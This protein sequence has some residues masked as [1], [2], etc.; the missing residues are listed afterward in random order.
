MFIRKITIYLLVISVLFYA[1]SLST[2]AQS[3]GTITDITA[4]IDKNIQHDTT[5]INPGT[6][7]EY[8]LTADMFTWSGNE[9]GQEGAPI[10]HTQLRQANITVRHS[11]AQPRIIKA[12]TLSTM[13]YNGQTTSCVRIEFAEE[14]VSV[15]RR[16]FRLTI[17]LSMGSTRKAASEITL[18]GDF[19]NE[20][21]EIDSGTDYV[22][23]V[24]GK[25]LSITGGHI[26][27]LE[28]DM[29]DGVQLFT[30][31][32]SG[33]RYYATAQ[34]R[35]LNEDDA[36]ISRFPVIQAVVRLKT[37]NLA[38]TGKCVSMKDIGDYHVYDASGTYLGRTNGLVS[39]SEIYYLTNEQI[40]M[41]GVSPSPT[42]PSGSGDSDDPQ[43]SPASPF[44]GTLEERAAR[45][46]MADAAKDAAAS[47]SDTATVRAK[48]VERISSAELEAMFNAA[49]LA[50]MRARYVVDTTVSGGSGIQGRIEINPAFAVGLDR[51][52]F[53]G[54]YTSQSVVEKT[55]AV[56]ERHYSNRISVIH[57]S[58]EGSY[59]MNVK[60]TARVDLSGI[61]RSSIY[62]YY[63]DREQNR[64]KRFSDPG[65]FIDRNG[66]I[67][68]NTVFG[69]D[70]IVSEGPL[71][72][73]Q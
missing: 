21:I 47:G 48:D 57:L 3:P 59:G 33:R 40:N 9:A 13:R 58:H 23:L 15:N 11:A 30:R 43:N 42:S 31:V 37:I 52:I 32:S 55:A 60:I 38:P 54:V 61:D 16:E 68:F 65:S 72:K 2:F 62:L 50:R 10:T 29:G 56:F 69:G 8:P 45:N 71:T 46:D 35:M 67:H 73:K 44:G 63:Y 18:F 26:S 49:S 64:I 20:E 28:I 39:F 17:F 70:V 27:N 53:L 6:T 66:F 41:N 7:V 36:M 4:R 19:E 24:G 25:V 22:S 34:N 14:F 51:D 5:S 1:L 12:I